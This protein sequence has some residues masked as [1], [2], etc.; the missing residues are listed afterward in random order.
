VSKPQVRRDGS[1]AS[2]RTLDEGGDA[3]A[4]PADAG[5][6]FGGRTQ[7]LP[8]I[9]ELPEM[10]PL[11]RD[12]PMALFTFDHVLAI[13]NPTHDILPDEPGSCASNFAA[14]QGA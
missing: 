10:P 1:Q 4:Q 2:V 12:R 7:R 8:P 13:N 14:Q 3:M 9:C 5:R 6:V 11:V